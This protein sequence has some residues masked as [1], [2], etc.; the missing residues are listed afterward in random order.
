[1]KDQHSRLRMWIEQKLV[2]IPELFFRHYKQLGIAD[3]EAMLLL[4][5]MAFHS[6]NIDFPTPGA[7]A[8]R[9]HL[10]EREITEKLQR[11]LQKGVIEITQGIDANGKIFEKYSMFPLWERMLDFIGKR[12]MD[13]EEQQ[14]KNEEGEIFTLFEQEF[15]RLLSPIEIETISSWLDQDHHSPKIIREA[16]KEA[17]LAGK[18]SFRY[19][20]RILFEWKKKNIRTIQQVEKQREQFAKHHNPSALSKQNATETRKKVPFY[21]WLEERE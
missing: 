11:L 9:M 2:N 16:L 21:N 17:V 13:Q 1:M 4:H 14:R 10:T 6:E 8:E 18:L 15:G 5:L 7:L 19:I 12:S 20:D 3:D